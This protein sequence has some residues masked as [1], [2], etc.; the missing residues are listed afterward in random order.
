MAHS[1][2]APPVVAD[3]DLDAWCRR[4]L[5]SGVE[6][7]L[8]TVTHLSAVVGV[9]LKDDREVVVKVRPAAP[10]LAVCT[11]VQQALWHAGFPCPRPLLGPVPFGGY[12][13]HAE[14]FVPGGEVLPVDGDAAE[15]YAALLADLVRLAPRPQVAGVLAPHPPWTAWDHEYGGVWPPPDDRDADLNAQPDSAWLD[16]VARRVQQ[17]LH[18]L[19][20]G[21]TVIG[22]GDFYAENLRWRDG[23][24]WA[25]HDWDSLISAPEAVIVG[26]AAA[27]WPIGVV[28]RP[29]TVAESAA[30]VEAYQQASGHSWSAEQVQ[31]SWA[32]GLWSAAFDAKKLALDGTVWLT[33][34]H[35]EQRLAL[36]GA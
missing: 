28:Q 14:V 29:A 15:R 22:H 31:A 4:W 7:T 11:A 25:V 20:A 18:A 9:R 5:G 19:P 24:P 26:L 35:A 2:P 3:A 12:A 10:R 1:M 17:R 6:Q 33:P 23:Q 27:V 34:E 36:A 13:A 8:F 30:F 21:P 32:A 16:D